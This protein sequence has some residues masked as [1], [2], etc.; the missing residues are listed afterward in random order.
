MKSRILPLIAASVVLAAG[1][2]QV[3]YK[4][5]LAT[6]HLKGKVKSCTEAFY[7][8][9]EKDSQLVKGEM[10]FK[11]VYEVD[12]N[13]NKTSWKEFNADGSLRWSAKSV[14]ESGNKEISCE[15]QKADGATDW[16]TVYVYDEKGNLT[17]EN[18]FDA[19]GNKTSRIEFK[20][21]ENGLKNE[22]LY[23]TAD[24][25][26][27]SKSEYKYDVAGN[28]VE[29]TVYDGS[30]TMKTHNVSKYSQ[31]DKQG[32]WLRQDLYANDNIAMTSERTI[33]YY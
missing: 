20:Y 3:Q 22:R 13:G 6:E 12:E 18:E 21:N 2:R 9:Q 16:K 25:S 7:P 15:A 32:N 30:G 14:Y 29:E 4:N 26:L 27:Y 5:F 28:P 8:I 31:L 1:C 11:T 10:F 19:A 33:E 23:Y 17:G 24:G